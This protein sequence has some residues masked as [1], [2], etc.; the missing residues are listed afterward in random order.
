MELALDNRFHEAALNNYLN[1]L[2]TR[3]SLKYSQIRE[4]NDLQY[5]IWV[6]K[7]GSGFIK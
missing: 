1:Y 4:M 7:Q 3:Y 6:L 2:K 5:Y